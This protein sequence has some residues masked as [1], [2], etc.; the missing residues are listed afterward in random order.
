VLHPAWRG[1]VFKMR[2]L[3]KKI[4]IRMLALLAHV[5]VCNASTVVNFDQK[6]ID[7]PLTGGDV[8]LV[9]ATGVDTLLI[10]ADQSSYSGTATVTESVQKIVFKGTGTYFQNV[11]ILNK[12]IVVEFLDANDGEKYV[13]TIPFGR[14]LEC[15]LI[16]GKNNVFKIYGKLVMADRS[17]IKPGGDLCFSE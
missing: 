8:T 6:G 13:N 7:H 1:Y 14:Q 10:T 9:P 4:G 2:K 17:I 3:M 16:L 15:F 11:N 12:K 5:G